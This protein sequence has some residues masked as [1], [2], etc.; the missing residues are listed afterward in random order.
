L[1]ISALAE[2]NKDAPPP[3]A[4]FQRKTA[5][6]ETCDKNSAAL[7]EIN[8]DAPNT[9]APADM[10][11]IFMQHAGYRY[12]SHIPDAPP[13]LAVSDMNLAIS[14]GDFWVILGRNGSGKSTLSRLMNALLLPKEGTVIID[15]LETSDEEH[16]WQIRRTVGV[17]FQNPDNQIVATTVE[18]DVAFGPE[19]LGIPQPEI[20]KRVDDALETVAMSGYLTHSPHMLSGG[21]KQR[22]AIAGILAMKPKCIVLDEAT[23]MLD[24]EGRQEV[25]DAIRSLHRDHGMTV[26]LITHHMEEAI[27]ADH[28]LVMLSGGTLMAGT[29][30]EVFQKS[31]EL[32][33]AGLDVPQMT[34]FGEALRDAGL[35]SGLLPVLPEEAAFMMDNV[36]SSNPI[37]TESLENP[38]CCED[39]PAAD[40]SGNR[41]GNMDATAIGLSGDRARNMD[42]AVIGLSGDR[43]GMND[44]ECMQTGCSSIAPDMCEKPDSAQRLARESA[45]VTAVEN[46]TPVISVSDLRHVYMPGTLYERTALDGITLSVRRGEVLGIIGH[47]G[48]GKS[49]L[50]QHLNGLLKATSG[51]LEVEGKPVGVKSLKSLRRKVGL[52]FQY[53]EHQLFE[54]T[55]YKDIAFGLL[56]MGLSKNETDKRVRKA[57]ALLSITPEMLDKSPFELSGG[58]K[59]RAAIAG[60]LVME[61]AILILDEPTAGLDPK[62]SREVFRL[63]KELNRNEGTTILLISHN[64]EDIAAFSDRVAVLR[65]GRLAMLGTPHAI[66]SQLEELKRMHLDVP[67]ITRFFRE[68]GDRMGK[69]FPSVL[70]VDEAVRF[71]RSLKV[72]ADAPYSDGRGDRS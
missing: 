18:E 38:S 64:M 30:G 17:V 67:A 66:F 71:I 27:G 41:A 6:G 14:Q 10:S 62:G 32:R 8:K 57:A 11:I 3:V 34:A 23:S 28:V 47:T 68:T 58:Q 49:P 48:S 33:E 54:E 26:I 22:V 13:V 39:V 35:Y 40:C 29:P 63:L 2:I 59:R 21:Q 25:L 5:I 31:A 65:D 69:R 72:P 42:A 52:I 70:T 7:A 55:V 12:L 56:Q 61:P 19:N 37:L 46:D 51:T 50:V 15:G 1:F 36:F 53:P 24:P 16:I 43:A 60:V 44:S 4:A 45:T 9:G 20:R